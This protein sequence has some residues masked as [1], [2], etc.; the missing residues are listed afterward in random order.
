MI[1]ESLVHLGEESSGI[2]ELFE[3]GT[4]SGSRRREGKCL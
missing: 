4:P 1:S 3:Y 2:R